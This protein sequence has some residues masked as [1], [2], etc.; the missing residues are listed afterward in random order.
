MKTPITEPVSKMGNGYKG[1]VIKL[2]KQLIFFILNTLFL[3]LLYLLFLALKKIQQVQSC[4]VYSLYWNRG[5]CTR[6]AENARCYI[7]V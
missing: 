6:D 3:Q 7:A 4:V 5:T 2:Q 1:K